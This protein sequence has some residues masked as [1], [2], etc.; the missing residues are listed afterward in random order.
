LDGDRLTDLMADAP[1]VLRDWGQIVLDKVGAKVDMKKLW[2]DMGFTMTNGKDMTSVMYRV[3]GAPIYEQ[4]LGSADAMLLRLLDGDETVGG[5]KQPYDPRIHFV[6][7]NEA[8]K[9]A[10]PDNKELAKW[11]DEQL[12]TFDKIYAGNRPRYIDGYKKLKAAIRPWGA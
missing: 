1:D 7:I 9:A 8:Y 11:L 3:H 4:T 10:N 6:L 2:V 5:E 12:A